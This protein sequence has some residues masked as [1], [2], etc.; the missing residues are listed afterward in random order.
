MEIKVPSV[1]ESVSEALVAKWHKQD[2]DRVEKDEVLCEIE[3]DKI[4]L[5][6]NADA[7]GTLAIRAREGET[8]KIGAVIGTIAEGEGVKPAGAAAKEAG[9]VEAKAAAAEPPMS[10]AVRKM[11]QEKGIKPE[12]IKGSGKGGRVT[13]DDLLKQQAAPSPQPAPQPTLSFRSEEHTPYQTAPEG[14]ITRKTMTPI[15]RK[16]AERLLAARQQTAMLTTFNE[17]DMGRVMELRRRHREQLQKKFGVGLGLMPFF[18]RACVDALKEF[19]AVNA[20]IDGDDIV[21]QHFYDL[22]IAVGGEKGLVVPVIRD[23]DRLSLVEMEQKIVSLV[24]QVEKNR[25]SLEDLT[26]GTFTISNGGVYGSMLSTPILNPP[27]S[28]VLG[29]HAIQERPVVRDGQVVVRPMMYLALSYDHRIIDGREA[30][31]FLKKVKEYIED[32]EEMLL[33]G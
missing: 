7:A 25:L 19:P 31:G 29:M 21:Y 32:P 5:E 1:G 13:V 2:G 9:P 24:A 15:R 26:G 20:R 14:R 23:A 16:I 4:T 22:G 3:T 33:E 11:A 12:T 18:I 17:V 27:Q 28:G 30:V 10:P 6:I 8:V